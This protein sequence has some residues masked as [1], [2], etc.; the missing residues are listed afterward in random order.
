MVVLVSACGDGTAPVT[1]ASVELTSPIGALLDVSASAQLAAVGKDATGASVSG[2]AFT[3]TSSNPTVVSVTAAT[4]QI[5]AIAPGTATIRAAAGNVSGSL[6]VT[7]VDADLEGIGALGADP[8]VAAL[9]GGTS[10]GVKS[11]L[12]TAIAQCT[13]GVQ[14]GNLEDIQSCIAAARSQATGATD[15]TDRALLSVLSLFADQIERLLNA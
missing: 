1:V 2:V 11:A 10:S 5:Q 7:V 9:V 13:S 3:W 8:Y 4:G 6:A 12:Q 14:Q 15:A